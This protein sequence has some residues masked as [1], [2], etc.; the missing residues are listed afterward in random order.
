MKHHLS[1]HRRFNPQDTSKYIGCNIK[2]HENVLVYIW[3]LSPLRWWLAPPVSVANPH[4]DVAMPFY[5]T[6]AGS[7]CCPSLRH[8][9]V[10]NE[11]EP[12]HLQ[13]HVGSTV[14]LQ[15][16]PMPMSAESGR[17]LHGKDAPPPIQ[18]GRCSQQPWLDDTKEMSS[19]SP[20]TVENLRGRE[21]R[22]GVTGYVERM[23]SIF[24]SI[25]CSMGSVF[26]E[27]YGVDRV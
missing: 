25:G 26:E 10:A 23:P 7:C 3:F 2:N 24:L 5:S 22:E 4:Q 8:P 17:E 15:V 21:M 13:I 19:I 27:T 1:I 14:F 16:P 9:I 6:E 11:H 18:Q 12:R 20:T